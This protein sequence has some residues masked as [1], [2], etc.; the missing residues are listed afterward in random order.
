MMPPSPPP[1]P[2]EP[3]RS[4]ALPKDGG[5]PLAAEKGAIAAVAADD[6]DDDDEG[7]V[8]DD[9]AG[10]EGWLALAGLGLAEL[11]SILAEAVIYI[12]CWS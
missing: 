7:L 4:D 9:D 6:D 5:E 2:C 1:P 11:W 12:P 8:E 3:A 10:C